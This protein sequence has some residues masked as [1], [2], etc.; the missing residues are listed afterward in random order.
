M[1]VFTDSKTAKLP[2]EWIRRCLLS[3]TITLAVAAFIA[4]ISACSVYKSN[5]RSQ[6]ESDS[7]GNLVKTNVGRSQSPP[8]N[9][10]SVQTDPTLQPEQEDTCWTQPLHE[11]L[12]DL[13]ENQELRVHSLNSELIEV[14]L[15]ADQ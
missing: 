15:V 4:L 11:P 1:E 12:W 9:P 7:K 2:L 8:R 3:A 5:G 6:F 10:V 14:C 13:P